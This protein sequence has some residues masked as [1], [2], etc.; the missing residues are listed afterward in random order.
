MAAGRA[1]LQGVNDGGVGADVQPV[2]RLVIWQAWAILVLV[3]VLAISFSM[4]IPEDR[5]VAVRTDGAKKGLVSLG[6]PILTNKAILSWASTSVTEVLTFGFNNYNERIDAASN[7]FTESGFYSFAK[8]LISSEFID[9]ITKNQQVFTA[10]PAGPPVLV[11]EGLV[12]EVYTWTVEVPIIR[13][14][15]AGNKTSPQKQTIVLDLVRV[16][17]KI[18]PW[19]I[20]IQRW[21]A[22]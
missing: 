22:M 16:P 17:T 3:A 19:G 8:A 13:T 7:R 14:T 15:V 10:A 9:S 12:D 1:S 2:I 6:Q 21:R 4:F 18:S 11:S 20:G 5:Y